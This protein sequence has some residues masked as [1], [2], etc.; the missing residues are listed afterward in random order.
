M[1]PVWSAVAVAATCV[2]LGAAQAELPAA[3]RAMVETEREF[4][5]AAPVKKLNCVRA[6][7]FPGKSD[8]NHDQ[9]DDGEHE[10]RP[11]HGR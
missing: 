5:R 7:G 8:D 11:E 6:S 10:Q 4:A 1:K 3:L 2:A 9:H